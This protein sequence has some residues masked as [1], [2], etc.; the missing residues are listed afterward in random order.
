MTYTEIKNLIE[1]GKSHEDIV[2]IVKRAEKVN[3]AKAKRRVDNAFA[4]YG[5]PVPATDNVTVQP[6]N[7]VDAR[8]KNMKNGDVVVTD[9]EQKKNGELILDAVVKCLHAGN[10]KPEVILS[11]H[12]LNP[13]DWELVSFKTGIW[14]MNQKGG[15]VANMHSSK[16]TVKP[17]NPNVFNADRFVD[18]CNANLNATMPVPQITPIGSNDGHVVEITIPDL[19]S[20]AKAFEHI[21]GK[22]INLQTIYNEATTAIENIILQINPQQTKK[23]MLV[24]LGDL[25][26][27]DNS[28]NTTTNYTPQDTD[29]T[30]DMMIQNAVTFLSETIV[31]LEQIAPVE[32]IYVPGNHDKTT[33]WCAAYALSCLFQT[34]KNVTFDITPKAHKFRIIGANAVGW[35]HGDT[36]KGN[37]LNGLMHGLTNGMGGILQRV[38]HVGHL[39]SNSS[40]GNI[41]NPGFGDYVE[42]LDSVC[43]ATEYEY[44]AAFPQ[45]PLRYMTAFMWSER[46]LPPNRLIGAVE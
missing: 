5:K 29:G 40:N 39:H 33:G 46:P 24:T 31:K 18:Y 10:V 30:V 38:L 21:T 45:T 35:T 9:I 32:Y 22:K 12:G 36:C 26:H 37:R 27:V 1:A 23:I 4:H 11:A 20:G 15:N 2:N 28:K 43:G 14:N 34:H 19:H 17:K 3:Y 25:I 8:F 44:D 41:F 13:D 6:K 7:N 16:V 42:H